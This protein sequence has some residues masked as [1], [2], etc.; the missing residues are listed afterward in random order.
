[1]ELVGG[2]VEKRV[3]IETQCVEHNTVDEVTNQARRAE[4]AE[5][6]A[7]A[8]GLCFGPSGLD[9]TRADCLMKFLTRSSPCLRV[10]VVKPLSANIAFPKSH[11]LRSIPC[12]LP[13]YRQCAPAPGFALQGCSHRP[14]ATREQNAA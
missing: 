3:L 7:Y 10:S 2:R 8:T 4:K 11:N 9:H 14:R 6:R 1:M 12:G 5:P 13:R